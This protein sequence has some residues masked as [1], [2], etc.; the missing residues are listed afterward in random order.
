MNLN[1][2]LSGALG[3]VVGII[4][5]H[6]VNVAIAYMGSRTVSYIG[7][8]LPEYETACLTVASTAAG[9]IYYLGNSPFEVGVKI[10]TVAAS[11]ILP[12]F[13]ATE[14]NDSKI[15]KSIMSSSGERDR[16]LLAIVKGGIAAGITGSVTNAFCAL[17]V[18]MFAAAKFA[19]IKYGK[20]KD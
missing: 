19:T 9:L 4:P 18:G 14:K 10:S 1:S 6:S 13:F 8:N 12:A 15:P 7:N 16:K 11:L 20:I 2:A 17:G 3:I 5:V